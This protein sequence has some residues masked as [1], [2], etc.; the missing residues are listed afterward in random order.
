MTITRVTQQMMS[1]QSLAGLQSNLTR[2]AELQEQMTTGRRI[3]RPSDSPIEATSAM[4]LRAS[5]TEAQQFARNSQD[6]LGWLGQL[7]TSL[8]T[9]S[10]SLRQARDLALTG[11]NG[12][13]GQAALDALATEVEQ[14]RSGLISTANATYLDRPVFGGITAGSTAY[15]AS[16]TYVGTTASVDRSIAPGVNISVN[17][18]A[19]TVLGPAGSSVFDELT[20]LANALRAGDM[21]AVR[22]SIDNLTSTS[23]TETPSVW[24]PWR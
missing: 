12:V 5:R 19:E 4:R 6:G 7:D 15:D 10:N 22:S 13:G 14:I 9:M 2:L 11:A 23:T 20:D 18:D 17:I 3:N 24:E 21:P 16:G 1:R 8:Q